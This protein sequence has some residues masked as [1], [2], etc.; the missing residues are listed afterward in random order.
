MKSSYSIGEF[1]QVTG[2]SVKTLRFYHEK[3][4]LVP[5]S[6]DET[7]GYRFY[8]PGKIEKARVIMRLRQMEFSIEDIAAVLGECSDEADVL[9]YLEQQKNLLQHRIQEDRDIV[10]SLNEIIAK[11]RAARQLLESSSFAVE[12]KDFEPMLIAGIRMKGK[13]RDCGAGFSRLGKA[14]GRYICGKALCL[15]YEAE[16]REDDANFEPCFPIRKEVAADGIS[17]RQLP[18]GRCLSLVHRGPYDQLGRSYAKILKQA[19]ERKW[20][21]ALPTREIYLKGPGMIFKGNPR[22]Y[23]TEIQLPLAAPA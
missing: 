1:S 12:E 5:S 8:D 11:E 9:N 15:Y 10:R 18:G 3:G 19:E 7:T 4:I 14:I 16:Y 22:N 2:L 13:Y 23:L 21:T 20:K 6:V 17:I